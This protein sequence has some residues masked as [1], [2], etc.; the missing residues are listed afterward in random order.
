ME[1]I[2]SYGGHPVIVKESFADYLARPELNA[3]TAVWGVKSMREFK[4]RLDN[5]DSFKETK[6]TLIGSAAHSM[7][8]IGVEGFLDKFVVMPAFHLSPDNMTGNGVLSTSKS[9]KWYKD[10]V[11]EFSLECMA[12][13]VEVVDQFTYDSSKRMIEAIFSHQPSR[14]IIEKSHHELTVLGQVGGIPAKGRVDLLEICN[15]AEGECPDLSDFKTTNDISPHAFGRTVSRFSY[16]FKMRW[17][18]L[19]LE[20]IGIKTKNVYLLAVEKTGSC[21]R[22]RYFMPDQV[23]EK[24]DGQINKLVSDLGAQ[25][26]LGDKATWAGAFETEDPTIEVMPWDMEQIE[27]M[28]WSGIDD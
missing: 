4:Y 21:D 2:Y 22:A 28:D 9:T 10:K 14:E 13:G 12:T 7:L 26:D 23:L 16:V 20:S 25:M 15:F 5:P 8:E 6:D 19:I 24:A 18:Q 11:A 17:Y 1:P 27:E 3:S